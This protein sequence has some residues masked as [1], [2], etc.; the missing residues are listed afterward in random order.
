MSNE[1]EPTSAAAMTKSANRKRIKLL[2][3]GAGI[4]AAVVV[5]AGLWFEGAFSSSHG[6]NDTKTAASSQPTFVETPEMVTNLDAGPHRLSFV[7]VQ[8]KI[9]VANPADAPPLTAAMP[10]IVDMIQ[11]Y[12][13]ET[14]PEELRSDAGTYRLREALLLRA[15]LA[16]P[17]SK[18][19]DILFEEL[20]VQ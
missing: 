2:I 15:T 1:P 4:V 14:R 19:K 7:K 5:G 9:E 10:R 20:I 18:V 17:N 16:S 8:C 13:R 11:T 3:G 6:S 12:L